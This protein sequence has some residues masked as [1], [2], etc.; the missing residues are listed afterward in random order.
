MIFARNRLDVRLASLKNKK[1]KAFGPFLTAGFPDLDS[2]AAILRGLPAAGADMIEIGVPFSDPMA[3]GP[4]IQSAN[5]RALKN[6]ICMPKILNAIK[7]FRVRDNDTPLLL[8]SYYNP[9]YTYGAMRFLDDAK[10]AGM[11]GLIVPDLPPEEDEELRKPAKKR[12]IHLI[13]LAT[14]TTDDTRLPFILNQ[15]RGFLYQISVSGISGGKS[16]RVED[17]V[18]GIDK[19]RALSSLPICIGFGVNTPEQAKEMASISDGVIVGSSIIK[20]MEDCLNGEGQTTPD[21]IKETLAFVAELAKAVHA[22]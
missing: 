10:K 22:A 9:I 1:K 11:D 21:T 15:A 17:L 18:E 6:G 19:I 8:M 13:R 12:G 7:Q 20:K 14:P 5:G 16:A 3:D 2:F 4:T